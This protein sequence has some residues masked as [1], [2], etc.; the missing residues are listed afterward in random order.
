MIASFTYERNF[1]NALNYIRLVFEAMFE[2]AD[3]KETSFKIENR[4]E[5]ILNDNLTAMLL[6]LEAAANAPSRILL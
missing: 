3:L 2:T 1:E 4:K 5:D 6:Q